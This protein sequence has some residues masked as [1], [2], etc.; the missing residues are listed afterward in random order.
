MFREL[1]ESTCKELNKIW[2][3]YQIQ[4]TNKKIE[5]IIK[6][7]REILELK[8]QLKLKKKLLE[9]LDNRLKQAYEKIHEH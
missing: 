1:K 6:N 3:Q 4:N 2:D 7:K 5:V 8:V 9:G